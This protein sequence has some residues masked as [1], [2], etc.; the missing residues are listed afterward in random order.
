VA[1][2]RSGERVLASS[3]RSGLAPS[4][5]SRAILLAWAWPLASLAGGVQTLDPVEVSASR[6]SIVGGAESASEGTITGIQITTRPWLRPAEL[7][8]S[9]PGLIVTQHSGDGKA[10]QYFLRGFNLD[11]GTDFAVSVMGMPVNL[12]THAHGQG[13]IDLNF[14]IPELVETIRYRKGPYSVLQGDFASAGSSAF[15]Y[16]RLLDPFAEVTVGNH[17]YLRV[18]GAGAPAVGRGNLLIAAEGYHNDG[19]WDVP[20]DFRKGNAVLRYTQGTLAEGYDLTGTYYRAKWTATDQVAQ[21]AIDA[22]LIGRFGS[23]DSS[24]GGDTERYSLSGQW[25]HQDTH[26]GWQANAYAFAYRLNLFSNFTYALNDEVNGDQFEQADRRRTWG[27]TLLRRIDAPVAGVPVQWLGGL[28]LRQDRIDPVGLYLTTARER[29]TTVRQDQV[30]QTQAAIFGEA[31]VQV[32]PW[33]S[34]VAG[35]R[36]DQMRVKVDSSLPENSG[37]D[38]QAIAQPKFTATFGPFR[39]TEFFVNWGQGYHSND[40]RGATIR[41][42]PD[43]RDPEYL[44]PVDQVP[45]L[46][47][48]TGGELGA[49]TTLIP[50]LQS[51]LALWQLNLGSELVFVGDAGLTE[52]TRP[53]RR[54]GVEWTNYWTP[55]PGWVVD[56]DLSWS[57]ARYTESAPEGDYIPGAIETTAQAGV[58]YDRGGAFFGGVRVRYFGAR[59]LVEDNSVRSQAST[60]ANLRL[61]WRPTRRV[62]VYLDV[63]N[64]FDTQVNDIEYWYESRLPGEAAAVFDRHIHPAEPRTVRLTLRANF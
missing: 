56:F 41:V 36:V 4:A 12:P 2:S 15:E 13:Y 44:N 35:L 23:L 48:T 8:E 49:R 40:A 22:G 42:N 43:P 62:E 29:L 63:L 33:M 47:R 20:Q 45:L 52:P 55:S 14:L 6:G 24:S 32:Q 53:S 46:V 64:L 28:Q 1:H 27:G 51:A 7:L 59:P 9:I 10:N 30:T 19:P 17:G 31:A 3:S 50:G 18:L 37:S 54:Y 25:G 38:S 26:G 57:H 34:L 11:H 61:G 16:R 39:Q 60:I 21:R 58:L 5:L